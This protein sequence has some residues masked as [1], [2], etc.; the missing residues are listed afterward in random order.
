M[1]RATSVN[2][3]GRTSGISAPNSQSQLACIQA[4]LKQAGFTADDIDYVEA[5]GTGTPLGDPIEMLALGQVFPAAGGAARPCYVSS[6]KANV[7]HMETVSG[8]AGLIKVVLMMQHDEIMR[9]THFESLNPHIKLEGT[10][11]VIPTE[12]V[13]WPRG[14]GRR[15]AG[16]SSF[17]FGGTNT[18]LIVE[19]A[20]PQIRNPQSAIERPTAAIVETV[21]KERSGIEAAGR[22]VGRISR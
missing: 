19:A 22:T 20:N 11:L 17:G 13:P 5:H 7:G 3:D 6:V 14:K 21:C 10:R 1:L 9:L 15:A 18:H 4:A 2:Q 12:H 8:V 16:V